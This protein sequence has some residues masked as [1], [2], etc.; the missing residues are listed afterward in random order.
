[1]VAKGLDQPAERRTP[2]L[3]G[4]TASVHISDVIGRLGV[5][6]RAE[7]VSIAHQRGL[8]EVERAG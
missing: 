3:S 6:G 5:S 7:A 1:M 4:R 2:V 8:L